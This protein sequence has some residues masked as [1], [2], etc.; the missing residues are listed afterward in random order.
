[1]GSASCRDGRAPALRYRLGS[2]DPEIRPRDEVALKV[3][4]VMDGSMQTQETLGGC[5]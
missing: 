1:V 4:R 2:E 5:R 3:E